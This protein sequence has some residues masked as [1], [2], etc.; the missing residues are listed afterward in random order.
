VSA[1]NSKVIAGVACD[2]THEEDSKT[3]KVALSYSERLFCDRR[4]AILC[5]DQVNCY[6][7]LYSSEAEATLSN[8]RLQIYM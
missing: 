1:L 7:K 8:E 4:L 6:S 5:S 2:A 3:L